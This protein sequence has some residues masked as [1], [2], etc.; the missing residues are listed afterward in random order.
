[1][2]LRLRGLTTVLDEPAPLRFYLGVHRPRWLAISDVRLFIARQAF[3]KMTKLPRARSPWALDS[4]GFTELNKHGRW[5]RTAREYVDD[6]RRLRDEVGQL[7]WAAPQD[8][9]CEEFVIRKTGLSVEEHQRRTVDNFVELRS[10]APDLPIA[11]V[12]QGWTSGSYLECAELYERAGVNLSAEAVVGVGSVCRRQSTDLLHRVAMRLDDL[13]LTNLHGFGLKK[14]GLRSWSGAVFRSADSLA[15]SFSER[16]Q[17]TG[18]QNDFDTALAWR[19]EM[20]TQVER[21]RPVE[22]A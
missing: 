1:V 8:W 14:T 19:E 22:R 10:M 7:E 9:M 4:G 18:M 12:L 3:G 13:G 16:R 2:Q 5:T 21:V 20:L 15:W 6:V 11:P 17:G